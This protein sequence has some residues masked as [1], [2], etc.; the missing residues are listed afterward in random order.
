MVFDLLLQ[1]LLM[2]FLA[3]ILVQLL[4]LSGLASAATLEK[5]SLEE[6]IQKSTEIVSGT[7][8]GSSTLQRGPVIYT[9]YRIRVS[10]QWKGAPAKELEVHVPGGKLG[11]LS[12]TFSGA[13]RLQEG[14]EYVFFLWSSRSGLTQVIGLSQGLFGL[15]RESS[16]EITLI[17]QASGEMMLDSSGRLV[18]DTP[19][20]MRLR[21]MVDRIHRTLAGGTQR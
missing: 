3:V 16:G 8:T 10:D 5:L 13:P 1:C 18:E 7:V 19:V 17:R 15:K 2:R 11:S 14:T 4:V 21:E 20:S 9:R 6:M 12:Q